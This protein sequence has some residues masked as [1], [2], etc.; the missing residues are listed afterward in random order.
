VRLD[1]QTVAQTVHR[2]AGEP[3][4]SAGRHNTREGASVRHLHLEMGH[5]ALGVGDQ[6]QRFEA[7][8]R[9]RRAEVPEELL[10]A[11]SVIRVGAAGE[12]LGDD[13]LGDSRIDHVE[14]T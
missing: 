5:H 6:C 12:A 13:I 3:N 1:D 10:V 14:I 11:L 2:H 9:E 8:V 7:H 4:A